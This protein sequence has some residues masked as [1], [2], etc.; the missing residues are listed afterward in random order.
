M[1]FERSDVVKMLVE[2]F[3]GDIAAAVRAVKDVPKSDKHEAVNK[4]LDNTVAQC[5]SKMSRK[6]FKK[7]AMTAWD[8]AHPEAIKPRAPNSWFIFRDANMADVKEK[9]PTMKRAELMKIV[10]EMYKATKTPPPPQP[11]PT[12][13]GTSQAK[14]TKRNR[15]NAND[16][17][18]PIAS[19]RLRTRTAHV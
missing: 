19:R 8:R 2:T 12:D 5:D 18:S 9:N 14:T 3:G 7:L 1:A 11:Q 6:I 16:N 17:Q 15:D 10:S 4:M 13:E